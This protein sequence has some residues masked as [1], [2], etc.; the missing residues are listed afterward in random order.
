MDL[1]LFITEKYYEGENRNKS[2]VEWEM[3]FE[4]S[5]PSSYRK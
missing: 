4:K 2:R 5:W 1:N 3:D